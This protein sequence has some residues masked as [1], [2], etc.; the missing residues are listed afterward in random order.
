MISE[1]KAHSNV[2]K[3]TFQEIQLGITSQYQAHSTLHL[4]SIQ[5]LTRRM[6]AERARWS[7]PD[8]KYIMPRFVLAY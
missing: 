4:G 2:H 6:T 5:I 1:K 7:E 8:G 3:T